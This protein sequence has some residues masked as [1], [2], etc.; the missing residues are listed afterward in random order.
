MRVNHTRISKVPTDW[1]ILTLKELSSVAITNGLYKDKTHYGQGPFMVHMTEIFAYDI[2]TNQEMP[3]VLLTEK[4]KAKYLL[5]AGDLLFARRSLKPEG[6]GDV[7]IVFPTS[8]VSFESSIIRVRLIESIVFPKFAFYYLKSKMGKAQMMSIVRQVAVS[9]ITG[10]DLKKYQIPLPPLAEQKSIVNFLETWDVAIQKTEALI[11]AKEKQFE[12]LCQCYFTF[13]NKDTAI[14]RCSKIG[15]FLMPRNERAVPSK[16]L[17]LYSLTI[18]NGI[19]A[20]T[21][22][23]DREFLVKDKNSKAYKVVHPK[24][25]VFNPANLRWGAIAR[26]EVSHKIVLSPIYEVFKVLEN[27]IDGDYLTYA[28]TCKRQI[29]IFATKTEGTL[30][31]RMGVKADV[32]QL[33]EIMIPSKEKQTMIAQTL[34]AARREINLLKSLGVGYQKQ[35]HYLMQKLLSGELKV[36]GSS[37]G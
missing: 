17:P 16:D 14:W 13:K 4:E 36:G 1:Q 7:S 28:L 15:D 11:A 3:Q 6:A 22:R 20:K 19:T 10:E 29:R 37:N 24:D 30:I 23:Y 25:I 33:C 12:W 18:D 26:S 21:D 8:E 27:K 32:F 2:I 35:K 5:K 9:G 34:S 31:E